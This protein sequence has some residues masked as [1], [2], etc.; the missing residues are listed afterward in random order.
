MRNSE[1]NRDHAKAD[2]IVAP[3]RLE[4]QPE[5]GTSWTIRQLDR[6]IGSQFYERTALSRNKAAM[7]RK[8]EIPKPEDAISP[9]HEIKDPYV[10]EFL[11]LKDE[12][13]ETNLEAALIARLETFLLELRDDFTFVG[14]QRRLRL[15][16]VWYR[17]DLLFFHGRLRCERS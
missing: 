5:S 12:Y 6:Q 15:D 11:G 4:A 14:R 13:S 3:L 7:M 10:L 8:G 2:V 17:V 9:E 1:P 16:D